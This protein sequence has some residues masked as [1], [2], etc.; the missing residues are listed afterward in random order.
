[1]LKLNPTRTFQERVNDIYSM[2]ERDPFCPL[3]LF[4]FYARKIHILNGKIK[5]L[6]VDYGQKEDDYN[7]YI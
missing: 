2:L 7:P 3:H 5:N 4:E 6:S 1:M